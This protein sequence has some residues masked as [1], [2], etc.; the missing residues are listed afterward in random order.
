M[1]SAVTEIGDIIDLQ[2]VLTKDVWVV[3]EE[4]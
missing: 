4:K 1:I 3:T 2:A